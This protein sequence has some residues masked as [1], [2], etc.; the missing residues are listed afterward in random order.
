M[1]RYG[2]DPWVIGLSLLCFAFFVAL[3]VAVLSA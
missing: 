3:V 2:A 1:A